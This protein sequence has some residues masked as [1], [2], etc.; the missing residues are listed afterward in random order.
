MTAEPDEIGRVQPVVDRGPTV[1]RIALG[2]QLRKLRESKGITR[3]AAGDAIRGSHAKISRL[4]LGRTGFKE[5]DIRDL[6]TL[7]GVHDTRERESFFELARQASEPGWW[8]RYSD[9]LPSWF[10]TY[11]GLEQAASQIR[12]YEAQLVPGLLQTPEYTRAIVTLGFDDADTERRV[13]VRQLRQDVLRRVDPPV[14]WAVIDEAVLHRPIGGH[15]VH[16]AQLRYLAELSALPNVTVQVLPYSAGGHAA[17]GSSFS[18]LRFAEPELPDI[19]YLEQLTSALYLE[20]RQDLALYLS[21]MDQLSVQAARPDRS[22][23]I[24]LDYADRA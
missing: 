22:R 4:E 16:R 3:E 8:H 23:Q 10:S 20:R 7:Y 9:L 18:I 12:T 14:V 2:G 17:A 5:R 21:V 24:L 15:E 19:V 11:L 1:L 6:L 13:Q